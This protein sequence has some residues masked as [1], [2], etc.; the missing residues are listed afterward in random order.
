MSVPNLSPCWHCLRKGHW[1]SKCP[2]LQKPENRDHHEARIATI[3]RW[4]TDE[5]LS[6]IDRTR[7]I[8]HE[9]ELW[10]E[11]QKEIARK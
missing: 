3:R 1:A 9:N 10:R 6:P 7:L 5:N 2:L 11:K 8:K 4:F